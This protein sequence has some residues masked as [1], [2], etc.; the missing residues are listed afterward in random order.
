[1]AIDGRRRPAVAVK[2]AMRCSEVVSRFLLFKQNL[3]GA[4]REGILTYSLARDV[5]IECRR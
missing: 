3:E 5:S 4:V 1:M 2:V